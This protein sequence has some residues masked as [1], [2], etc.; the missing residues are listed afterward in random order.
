MRYNGMTADEIKAL[1]ARHGLTQVQLAKRVK[2]NPHII[3][4]WERGASSP[5]IHSAERLRAVVRRLE[6][7]TN[8][9]NTP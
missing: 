2:V 5:D 6:R 7:E 1:R 4:R 3:S 8:H 9:E